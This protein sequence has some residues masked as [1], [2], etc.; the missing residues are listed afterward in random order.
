MASSFIPA[1]DIESLRT[2]ITARKFAEVADAMVKYVETR[3]PPALES[4]GDTINESSGD[5]Q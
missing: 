4:S 1:L 5:T 3:R 2:L